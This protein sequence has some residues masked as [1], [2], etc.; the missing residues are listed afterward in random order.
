MQQALFSTFW[1]NVLQPKAA[2]LRVLAG[3]QNFF[4]FFSSFHQISRVFFPDFV[5]SVGGNEIK[6]IHAFY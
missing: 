5:D 1:G 2:S 4:Q 6:Y 3:I